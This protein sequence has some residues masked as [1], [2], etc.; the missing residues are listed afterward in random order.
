VGLSLSLS[1]R[2][3][4]KDLHQKVIFESTIISVFS[5]YSHAGKTIYALNLALGL[6]Q[7]AHKSVII[8]D[9]TTQDK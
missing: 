6:R 7:E 9:L 8:L 5:S 3:K 1:R 2:L 4:N